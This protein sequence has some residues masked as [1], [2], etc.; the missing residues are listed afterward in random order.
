MSITPTTKFR[1]SNQ[2]SFFRPQAG[3]MSQ[4][5]AVDLEVRPAMRLCTNTGLT[6]PECSCAGCI[7]RQL[8]QFAPAAPSIRR[9]H[10][11]LSIREARGSATLTPPVSIRLS[12]PAL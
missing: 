11:P 7:Q 9:I 2:T 12:R 10:D 6:V 1:P 8:D 3:L 4:P 5:I